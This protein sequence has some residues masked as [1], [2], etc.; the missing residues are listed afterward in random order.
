MESA[1]ERL[2]EFVARFDDEHHEVG[3]HPADDLDGV[4]GGNGDD[5][6]PAPL[7]GSRY[8]GRRCTV[9]DEHNGQSDAAAAVLE[10]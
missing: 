9:D 4:V 2:V 8:G 7:A 6:P 3:S 5:A 1:E 10:R